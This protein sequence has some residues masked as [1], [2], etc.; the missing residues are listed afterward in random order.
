MKR[1]FATIAAVLLAPVTWLLLP[2]VL[3]RLTSRVADVRDVLRFVAEQTRQADLSAREVA[4][5]LRLL[6]AIFVHAEEPQRDR[7]AYHS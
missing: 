6:R 5:E 3:F 7:S 4:V 2:V 1:T